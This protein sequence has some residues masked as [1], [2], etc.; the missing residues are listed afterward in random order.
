MVGM[1]ALGLLFNRCEHE[2]WAR[3]AEARERG[4]RGGGLVKTRRA[5]WLAMVKTRR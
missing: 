1:A 2:D 5:G 4:A 3:G